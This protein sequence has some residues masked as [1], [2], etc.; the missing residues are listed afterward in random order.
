MQNLAIS[1]CGMADSRQNHVSFVVVA[2]A[3]VDLAEDEATAVD[4]RVRIVTTAGVTPAL[5]E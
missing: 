5:G 1:I 2:K 4:S 3:D